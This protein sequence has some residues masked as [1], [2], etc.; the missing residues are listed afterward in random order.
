MTLSGCPGDKRPA[1]SRR[2]EPTFSGA[3][4][5]PTMRS[6]ACNRDM[7]SNTSIRIS[8]AW[9]GR[10]PRV[11]IRKRLHAPA[12]VT[13]DG[14]AD[15]DRLDGEIILVA[16]RAAEEVARQQQIHDLTAAVRPRDVAPCRSGD[17][18]VPV[19]GRARLAA[20]LLTAG[21]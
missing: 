11:R 18:E 21:V 10:G 16:C 1:I 17:D 7:A 2:N 20:N 15:A 9:R 12:R 3:V 19:V 13:G 8:R 4:T 6:C 14:R 5:R